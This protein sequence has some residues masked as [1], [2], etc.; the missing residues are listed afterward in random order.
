M[1]ALSIIA[2]ATQTKN[3][4]LRIL[5]QF[6]T[7]SFIAKATTMVVQKNSGDKPPSMPYLEV[8]SHQNIYLKNYTIKET[9]A[10]RC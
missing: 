6:R 8:L 2:K 5:T 4:L 9:Q 7:V 10:T 1:T 3:R